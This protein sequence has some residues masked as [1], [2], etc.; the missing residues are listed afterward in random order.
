[1]YF[2]LR[3]TQTTPGVLCD[4]TKR[5]LFIR[6]ACFP[7]DARKFFEP[8]GSFL[9][10]HAENLSDQSLEVHIS[11]SYINSSAQRELYRLLRII[12]SSGAEV[13]VF[14]YVG[15]REELEDLGRLVDILWSEGFRDIEYKREYLSAE[16]VP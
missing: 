13:R 16:L 14:V 5:Q 8:L 15:M 1:M 6:G 9:Q 10:A 7:E 4:L 12:L 3:S 2:N 11:L